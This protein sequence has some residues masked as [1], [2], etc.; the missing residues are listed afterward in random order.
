MSSVYKYQIVLRP[1]VESDYEEWC[2]MLTDYYLPLQ[3]RLPQ[4]WEMGMASKVNWTIAECDGKTA[5]FSATTTHLTAFS[6][7]EV[8]YLSDLYVKPIYR[9]R[10]IGAAF[11]EHLICQAREMK[12]EKLYWFTEHTNRGAQALYRKYARNDFTKF[13]VNL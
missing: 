4:V 8:M 13:H 10:G 7:S 3:D 12:L 5:G 11:M 2:D 1:L 6:L 9:R